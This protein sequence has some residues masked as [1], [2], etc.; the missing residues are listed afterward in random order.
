MEN[1]RA[2]LEAAQEQRNEDAR[3]MVK[4][5]YDIANDLTYP[6]DEHGNVMNV[7]FLIPMLSF[8][9]A[10]CGYVKDPSKAKIIQQPVPGAAEGIAGVVEDAVRYVP[11][12]ATGQLPEV[13]KQQAEVPEVPAT[14]WHTRTH[15]T[16]DG[17]TVKGGAR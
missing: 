7:H 12:D 6:V 1:T 8:H 11:V 14:G 10:R 13:F 3:S 15:I 16:L 2:A 17:E 5:M 9:L 4:A